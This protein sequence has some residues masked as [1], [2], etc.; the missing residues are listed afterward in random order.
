MPLVALLLA[1]CAETPAQRVLLERCVACHG[2]DKHKGDLRLDQAASAARVLAPGKPQE[3][4]L[5]RRLV[6]QDLEERMPKGKPALPA[7]EI[8]ILRAWI[9][10]GAAWPDDAGHWA[11]R[12]VAPVEIPRPRGSSWIRNPIDAFVLARLEQ[13]GLEPQCEADARTL[14]RRLSLDLTGL[15]PEPEEAATFSYESAVERL[16][17]SPHFGERWAL[18]WLDLA[19][20]ADTNGYE[21]DSRRSNWAWRDWVIDA[22]NADMPFDRFTI[23]QLAGDL[24]PHASDSQRIATG[25]QRNTLVNQEGGTDPEEFRYAAVVDR[26]NT[27]ASVWLGSTLGCAQCHDHKYDPFSQRDYYRMLAFFDQSADT[28]NAVEPLLAVPSAEQQRRQLELAQRA[29]DLEALLANGDA[30]FEAEERDWAA[31]VR[32]EIRATNWTAL[33]SHAE[34]A[35]LVCEPPQGDFSLLR[36]EGAEGFTIADLQ[37]EFV[38]ADGG[39]RPIALLAARG[40]RGAA[41]RM[42]LSA[43]MRARAG[44]K[45]RLRPASGALKISVSDDAAA[46]ARMLPAFDAVEG[47]EIAGPF[48]GEIPAAPAWRPETGRV[49]G[50]VRP[51][52][53][54]QTS[55]LWRRRFSVSLP[56]RVALYLGADDELHVALDGRVVY[57]SA[58]YDPVLKDAHRVVLDLGVGEH[59]LELRVKNGGGP[60]GLYFDCFRDDMLTGEIEEALLAAQPDERVLGPYYRRQVSAR[61]RE[62]AAQLEA[63]KR[64]RAELAASTPTTMV[65]QERTEKRVTHVHVKG[66]FLQLGEEVTP[67]TPA[68]LPPMD[69]AWPKNRLGLALWLVDPKNPLVARVQVNRVWEQL[70]GRGLVATGEDFGTR[71]A[72]PTHPELLDWLAAELVRERWSLKQ[73]LRTIVSSATYRQAAVADAERLERDP[74]AELYSRS[75]RTRLPGELLRDNALAIAGLLDRRLGGPSVFPPQPEGVWAPVYSDDKWIESQGGERQRRGLYTFWRRSSPYASFMLFDAPSR[76]ACCP[77][78]ARTDTPLQALALLND[79]AFV[80]CAKAL[81]EEMQHAPGDERARLAQGFERCTA[82]VPEARE[83]DALSALLAAQDWTAVANV[84]LNL[85]ETLCRP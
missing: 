82:R 50:A 21:K 22:F 46:A 75:P 6:T 56:Q 65:M 30:A 76:E 13:A 34:G 53:E 62:L 47:W 39:V 83:L 69:P 57:E 54:T 74:Q 40:E 3:S 80:E 7:A 70:F 61:G 79:P 81:G 10:A 18:P 24:L 77:R 72:A 44:E 60:G 36:V 42:A 67:D 23:E 31:R 17:A 55:W 4:E 14:L 25:F 43:P 59:L 11:Y 63:V 48:P 68:C 41:T 9:A 20:Y 12:P 64:E 84:L 71:G 35:A 2:P 15:P 8:E 26:T 5:Y 32:P 28:G 38:G 52:T 27:A 66:A 37:A 33:D 85:D 29:R 45:L 73:L 1:A 49:R 19:R 16:L 51:I 78:R 58:Q